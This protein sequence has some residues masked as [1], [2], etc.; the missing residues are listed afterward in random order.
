MRQDT[1]L[2]IAKDETIADVSEISATNTK[3]E[4]PKRTWK[5]GGE[6]ACWCFILFS[7]GRLLVT[8]P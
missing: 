3:D 4:M 6:R 1:T 7:Y 2:E 8:N 5:V